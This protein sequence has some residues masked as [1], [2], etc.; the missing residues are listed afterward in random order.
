VVVSQHIVS[1]E[2]LTSVKEVAREQK[3]EVFL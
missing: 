2:L 1:V 3:I